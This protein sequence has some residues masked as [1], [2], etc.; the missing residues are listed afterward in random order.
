MGIGRGVGNFGLLGKGLLGIGGYWQG[1]GVT[2]GCK[3]KDYWVLG[4]D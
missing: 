4:M 1:G 2:L 3:V